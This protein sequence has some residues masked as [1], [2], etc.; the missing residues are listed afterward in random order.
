[1][2]QL[3]ESE[4][5]PVLKSIIPDQEDASYHLE[6]TKAEKILID[7][8]IQ[9]DEIVRNAN[10]QATTIRKRASLKQQALE[11]ALIESNNDFLKVLT[12]HYEEQ[13]DKLEKA[14][15]EISLSVAK[16]IIGKEPVSDVLF[17]LIKENIKN[18]DNVGNSYRL[19]VHPSRSKMIKQLI[20]GLN[21]EYP[22]T[23]LELVSDD[24]LDTKALKLVG[25]STNL[26]IGS[27]I[28]I[29]NLQQSLVRKR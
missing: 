21:I 12:D 7:A 20:D 13:F 27:D 22:K 5:L 4:F 23:K 26:E 14:I 11:E 18:I 10:K 6:K 2:S 15:A 24:T 16:A 1:M 29:A 9:A 17:H 8:H 28:A 3:I 25:S 19:I